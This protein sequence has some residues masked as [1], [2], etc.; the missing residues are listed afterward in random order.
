ME[1]KRQNNFLFERYL[2]CFLIF[3]GCWSSI[4]VLLLIKLGVHN[5]MVYAIKDAPVYLLMICSVSRWLFFREKLLVSILISIFLIYL[6]SNY[7]FLNFDYRNPVANI[8]QLIAPIVVLYFFCSIRLSGFD[9]RAIYGFLKLNLFV[10]FLWGGV[11]LY[12]ELWKKADLSLFFTLKGIPV[13]QY[14]LSYMFYEPIIGYRERM[15]SSFLDPISLGHFFACFF[16]LAFYKKESFGKY[17]ALF[18]FISL[19]GLTLTFSK[20]AMLQLFV[21]LTVLNGFIP[22]VIRFFCALM[23]LMV[24]L[25]IPNK[26]GI[27]IHLSGLY[28][29]ITN[30][31]IF[32]YGIG[33]VGNYAKMF[34]DDLSVY[35]EKGI[36]DTYIGSLLGQIGSL[37]LF[38]WLFLMVLA[39]FPLS[40]RNRTPLILLSSLIA[41]SAV[42]ENTL[43]ITSFLLPAVLIAMSRQS[44]TNKFT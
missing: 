7:I 40:N 31:N 43:N 20:G 41:V 33:S 11:E 27:N 17:R 2:I 32:G 23:P 39:I 34:S 28:N 12:F 9:V 5:G 26:T 38:F 13:D 1:I 24:Y 10:V 4:F 42:S 36:S 44:F 18:L 25:V 14:G 8:R 19:L 6:F 29:S 16:I 30:I 35:Y 3:W 21:A 15:T 22:L 37:G